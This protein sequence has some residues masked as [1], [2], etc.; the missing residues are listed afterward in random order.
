MGKNEDIVLD[1]L[2]QQNVFADLFNGY[3]FD[4]AQVIH[5][6]DLMNVDGRLKMFVSDDTRKEQKQTYEV[7]KKERDIVREVQIENCKIRLAILGVEHQS[8]IDYSMALR[9]TVYDILE[10]LKQAREIQRRHKQQKDVKGKE[11]LSK[12]KK[13]DRLIPTITLVFYTGQEP[14]DGAVE[15]AEL[16][17]ASPYLD[18]LL[19]H[20]VSAPLNLISV[21]NVQ[22]TEKY[23]GSLKEVFE[24]LHFV[25]DGEGMLSYVRNHEEAYSKLDEATMR[26][27]SV[28]IHLDFPEKRS[29]KEEDTDMCKALEDIKQMGIAEGRVEGEA[30]IK[31]SIIL[32]MLSKG[33]SCEE[34]SSLT[35]IPLELI[36][37]VQHNR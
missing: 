35:D 37:Q 17:E 5:A 11:Y 27:L 18:K 32:T 14:W 3:I 30:E 19:P 24:L 13:E 34:I 26:L 21:Y 28:L 12:F 6:G 2:S 10:Y 25:E 7:I 22:D 15:L 33:I 1:Y 36:K 31:K 8:E 29:N 20:M 23:H 16:Y 9:T 4:G